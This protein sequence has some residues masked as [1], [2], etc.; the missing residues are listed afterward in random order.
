M[1]LLRKIKN[2]FV[3]HKYP[4]WKIY[5]MYTGDFIGYESS[6]YDEIPYGWRKSFGK[7]LS[8]ELR[9]LGEKL[10]RQN[11]Q[12]TWKDILK[13]DCVKEKWGGLTIYF[14]GD[15]SFYPIIEKYRDLS[16]T[17]CIYCG[18]SVKYKSSG[19]IYFVCGECAKKMEKTGLKV[20][21][22]KE[23]RKTYVE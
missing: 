18:K 2:R 3:L 14:T 22:L 4:F 9:A 17:R 10:L 11:P 8:E 6:W 12:L 15:D 5:N 21:E 13:I 16:F 1:K 7:Q 19:W 23:E 20:T